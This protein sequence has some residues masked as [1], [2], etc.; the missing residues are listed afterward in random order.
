MKSEQITARGLV[1]IEVQIISDEQKIEEFTKALEEAGPMAGI[2]GVKVSLGGS[3]GNKRQFA[4]PLDVIC[5][6]YDI[7]DGR[8]V[9]LLKDIELD[10]FDWLVERRAAAGIEYSPE[11]LKQL[12]AYR[13]AIENPDTTLGQLKDMYTDAFNKAY[14]E[15]RRTFIEK[16][17]ALI[18]QI[19]SGSAG[20]TAENTETQS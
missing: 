2:E 5:A 8:S 17:T 6:A 3:A 7:K 20:S 16:N 4:R 12:R 19:R 13:E 1:G 9:H 14:I 15:P 10:K 18:E 11:G